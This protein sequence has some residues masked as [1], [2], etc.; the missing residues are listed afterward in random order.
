MV[1]KEMMLAAILDGSAKQID[2]GI[3]NDALRYYEFDYNGI[4]FV[5][6]K[7]ADDEFTDTF[8]LDNIDFVD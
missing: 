8:D 7:E 1:N 5:A 2:M 6:Y 3:M 4:K